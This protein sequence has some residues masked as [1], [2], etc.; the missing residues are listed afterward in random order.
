MYATKTRISLLK[1][2]VLMVTVSFMTAAGKTSVGVLKP[3]QTPGWADGI[4][5]ML[6]FE[7]E[8]EAEII[9]D[10]SPATLA[11]FKVVIAPQF[12]DPSEYSQCLDNLR[13]W[14]GEGGGLMTTHDAVGYRKHP[15][16]FPEI[17]QGA[18]HYFAEHREPFFAELCLT[19]QNSF[20]RALRHGDRIP[21]AYYD[22]ITL[23]AGPQGRVLAR[24]VEKSGESART[25][26]PV[27]V[28][29]RA[30]QGRYIAC[31]ALPGLLADEKT[32][33]PP[34]GAERLFLVDC[35]RYL[36]G[37]IDAPNGEGDDC[38]AE[39][40]LGRLESN[41]LFNG[42]AEIL[43]E[44]GLPVS[45]RGYNS[46]KLKPD[47]GLTTNH[48][49]EGMYALRL[50]AKGYQPQDVTDLRKGSISVQYGLAGEEA[51]VIPAKKARYTFSFLLKGSSDNQA[52]PVVCPLIR[53]WKPE[54]GKWKYASVRL[55]NAEFLPNTEWRRCEV[56]FSVEGFTRIMPMIALHL[57]PAERY[58]TSSM[59]EKAAQKNGVIPDGPEIFLDDAVLTY[60]EASGDMGLTAENLR[61][62]AE[63]KIAVSWHDVKDQAVPE[64]MKVQL[65][66]SVE[67]ESAMLD[68]PNYNPWPSSW[69]TVDLS[70][71]W[72][73]R[74]L[75]GALEK[76]DARRVT[77]ANP[78]DDEG[79][80]QGYWRSDYDDSDWS[81]RTVPGFWGTED[82]PLDPF[83]AEYTLA[84]YNR[85][86]FIGVGWYRTRFKVEDKPLAKR[87][88][89]HFDR[90]HYEATVY[91]NDV[92][93]GIN[94]GG[95][96]PFEFDVTDLARVG[97]NTLAVRVFLDHTR[98]AYFLERY[99]FGGIMGRVLLQ[100]RPEI[101]AKEILIDPVFASSEAIFKVDLI[102]ASGK[103]RDCVLTLGI[104]PSAV[105]HQPNGMQG[106]EQKITPGKQSL[107]PGL[108]RM[109]FRVKLENAVPWS[110]DYPYLYRAAL[111]ADGQTAGC[112]RFGVREFTTKDHRV[113]LNGKPLLPMGMVLN[114]RVFYNYPGVWENQHNIMRR[115]LAAYKELGVNMIFPQG[116]HLFYPRVFYD[117]CDEL[118]IM[119]QEWQ[120]A[121]SG[122]VLLET[123]ALFDDED[124][125]KRVRYIYNHPSFVMYTIGNECRDKAFIE[126][127]NHVYDLFKRIDGQNRPVCDTS[128]GVPR[129]LR[130][131][132][133]ICDI[134]AYFGIISGH[135][136]DTHNRFESVN[137]LVWDSHERALPIGNWEMGGHRQTFRPAAFKRGHELFSAPVLA[138]DILIDSLNPKSGGYYLDA[139]FTAVTMYGLRRLFVA[140]HARA[141]RDP[142]FSEAEELLR[143][144][145]DS[146][147]STVFFEDKYRAE[148]AIKNGVEECRRLGEL[149]RFGF[150]FNLGANSLFFVRDQACRLS[151]AYFSP[152]TLC[153][154]S[155][156][157]SEL[158]SFYKRGYNPQ[159]ICADVFDKNCF[160]GR[161]LELMI[162]AINDTQKDSQPWQIRLVIQTKT[163][164]IL[165][166]R[167]AEVGSVQSFRR[168]L[169]DFAYDLPSNIPTGFY[170]IQMYLMEDDVA[171]ADNYYEFFV[172]NE[173]DLEPRLDAGKKRTAVY[174]VAR[175]VLTT[176]GILRELEVP[177]E[178]LTDFGKLTEYDVL[179]IGA[180]SLDRLILE[181]G[182]A[183][184][185]WVQAGGRLLQFEQYNPV[186]LP[187]LTGM[188]IIKRQGGNIGN[189]VVI[190][191]PIFEKIDADQ[192]WDTWNGRLEG[193]FQY[194]R[195]GGIFTAL[196]GPLN[197]T[198]LALGCQD[199]PRASQAAVQML[200]A[201]IKVGNG[202]VLLSQPAATFRYHQD[203]V[204]AKYIRNCIKHILSDESGFAEPLSKLNLAEVD[205]RSCGYLDLSRLAQRK[206][207]A[208]HNWFSSLKNG[209]ENCGKVQFVLPESKA[210]LVMEPT[211][212]LLPAAVQYM[213]PQWEK[214][215]QIVD[216]DQGPLLKDRLNN[217]YLMTAL[218]ANSE[219]V[220]GAVARVTLHYKDGK[221]AIREL[222][223][224]VDTAVE[225]VKSDQENAVYVGGGLYLMS[226]QTPFP[227]DVVEKIVFEPL[228]KSG[229]VLGGVTM[230]LIRGKIHT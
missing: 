158:Y 186:A 210:A 48:A 191:H 140:D 110:L 164:E 109:E 119:I 51:L 161:K 85:T 205:H 162:Y 177:F 12:K 10:A 222:T 87:L 61:A 5:Q 88:I 121:V 178:P 74:K 221:T 100:E 141:L 77:T 19:R 8:F 156:A 105:N 159:F 95:N 168:H 32:I 15:A 65:G 130:F 213:D 22:Y 133:D 43:D 60:S 90:V 28:Y 167:I 165:A 81:E 192:N 50:R 180:E 89:L 108:N 75:A 55:Q 147:R 44:K 216:T 25:A 199:T 71:N 93:V 196:I 47:W 122:S 30:G 72:K 59:L 172:L 202:V 42:S 142:D 184:K 21:L 144:L 112:E 137:Q 225:T 200:I 54:D 181:Q 3:D 227:E 84:K 7:K 131:K 103:T 132:T 6:S 203:S 78:A 24:G 189:P 208:D 17:A 38:G 114:F 116:A 102:N 82:K 113:L 123:C 230:T 197:K 124:T 193:A 63:D 209:I 138:K 163:G 106:T 111:L 1:L 107:Q 80:V 150:G 215:K 67:A 96:S 169:L 218:P 101:Y 49:P 135:P 223:I 26:G 226:W 94:R 66:T 153:T 212:F 79:T 13:A 46:D 117:I 194:G 126:P 136:F 58:V 195:Q 175:Q 34:S 86:D 64:L 35:V 154:G 224:G 171:V 104:E 9:Y 41:L 145:S 170:D 99:G 219:A 152:A 190:N 198:M 182:E 18:F 97:E 98:Y 146:I 68:V 149:M 155:L 173:Q 211:E 129:E 36:A 23:K 176:S 45:I 217:L 214:E 11:K 83:A 69:K 92:Q 53:V 206:I 229:I 179:I 52:Q 204:A 31:G 148:W 134:H 57:Y 4:Y 39:L 187:W 73:I 20:V 174:D 62:G 29:G 56:S 139:E 185:A 183:I 166:D 16:V 220:T 201:E 157:A 128:G 120:A 14:V 207:Q 33:E 188:S 228:T 70:G 76:I 2:T 143:N 125:I 151:L 91:L 27:V 160:A 118:G 127:I 37:K 115:I 40:E